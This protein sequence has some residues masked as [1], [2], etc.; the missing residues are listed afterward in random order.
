MKNPSLH[1]LT[2]V[3][4]GE[5]DLVVATLYVARMRDTGYPTNDSALTLISIAQ[6]R[7]HA[8]SP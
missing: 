6:S 1:G 4:F 7:S 3:C 2:S 8:S 5:I